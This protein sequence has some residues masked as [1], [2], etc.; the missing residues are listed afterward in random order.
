MLILA[1]GCRKQAEVSPKNEPVAS[2]ADL[3]ATYQSFSG[4]AVPGRLK[5]QIQNGKPSG[6]WRYNESGQLT[7][8]RKFYLGEIQSADQYRYDAAGHLRFVQYFSNDCMFSSA[9]NCTG[10]VK[11]TRYDDL[12]TNATGRITKSSAYLKADGVWDLRSVSKYEYSAQGQITRI[13]LYDAKQVLGRTQTLT[14]DARGNVATIEERS[15]GASSGPVNRTFQYEYDDKRNPYFKTVYFASAF[16]LSPSN[17][18][19]SGLSL[20]YRA[21]GLPIR[22]K[23]NG[24]V[25]ELMYY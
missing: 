9:L 23:Q 13:L 2:I 15:T 17:Q 10:P 14:Y 11:W 6:E 7:E 20:E 22:K 1:L 24:G 5:S 4:S 3:P 8:L 18:L 25:T 16:F 19:S 21:D 12:T